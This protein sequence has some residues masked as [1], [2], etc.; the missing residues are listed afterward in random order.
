MLCFRQ[1]VFV[2]DFFLLFV[3]LISF[4]IQ[5]DADFIGLKSLVEQFVK[6]KTDFIV[7]TKPQQAC[8]CEWVPYHL[9]KVQS[10]E[11]NRN[12]FQFSFHFG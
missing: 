12:N 9:Q 4:S 5:F 11:N 10:N 8:K 2:S 7:S 1:I 6:K 3:F